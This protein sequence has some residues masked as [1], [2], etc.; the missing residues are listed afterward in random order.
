MKS[1]CL[2][3]TGEIV[4]QTP[5]LLSLVSSVQ[6]Y[7]VM[8]CRNMSSVFMFESKASGEAIE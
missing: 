7:Q 6:Q 5:I 2:S 1:R 3:N 4:R 8:T